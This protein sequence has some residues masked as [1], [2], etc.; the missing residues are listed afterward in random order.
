MNKGSSFSDAGEGSGL[1]VSVVFGFSPGFISSVVVSILATSSLACSFWIL[2][3]SKIKTIVT[4]RL[5]YITGFTYTRYQ[6]AGTRLYAGFNNRP[7][8]SVAVD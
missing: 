3:M 8:I 7:P 6:I 4:K 5:H 2:A 1:L